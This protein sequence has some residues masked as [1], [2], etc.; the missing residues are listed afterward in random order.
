[1][2]MRLDLRPG[3][4]QLRVAATSKPEGKSGSV[5]Y[6]LDVPDFA[7]SPLSVSGLVLGTPHAS[8]RVGG[9]SLASLIP[10]VP[11][12]RRE[13]GAEEHVFALLRLYQGGKG[14]VAPATVRARIVDQ[15]GFGVFEAADEILPDR[16]SRDRSADYRL[17]LPLGRLEAGEHLLTVEARLRDHTTQSNVRLLIR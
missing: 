14:T 16:F 4:Y 1:M 13:F 3:R 12:T 7:K 15:A 10:L 8:T 2:L 6:D 9:D 5:Y 17:E 11:T